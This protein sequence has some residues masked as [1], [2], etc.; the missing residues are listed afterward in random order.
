MPYGRVLRF[1]RKRPRFSRKARFNGKKKRKTYKAGSINRNHITKSIFQ[2]RAGR[3]ISKRW[4]QN[5][6]TGQ[7]SQIFV[8][9]PWSATNTQ[10]NQAYLPK[11][12]LASQSGLVGGDN[13]D[14]GYFGGQQVDANHHS[15]KDQFTFSLMPV[16]ARGFEKEMNT[17]RQ[18]RCVGGV[19][20]LK[21][22][23]NKTTVAN[24]IGDKDFTIGAVGPR[25]Y[26]WDQA[27]WLFQK[28]GVGDT[29]MVPVNENQFV[30]LGCKPIPLVGGKAITIK[31]R[32]KGLNV[33]H[34][35]YPP[36]ITGGYDN[37]RVYHELTPAPWQSTNSPSS[38]DI[39]PN[40]MMSQWGRI[41]IAV[42][43][44]PI[45]PLQLQANA[46]TENFPASAGMTQLTPD[47][48]KVQVTG[49]V[50]MQYK[51]KKHYTRNASTVVFN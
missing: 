32:A 46:I 20:T 16:C 10:M 47:C 14:V 22:L 38:S 40:V 1:K 48:C 24:Q 50:F 43:N 31:M 44:C 23:W 8:T 6:Q 51:G 35:M 25:V 11:G 26:I 27:Q 45:A 30:E 34:D 19:L 36:K 37:S 2:Q 4:S 39:Q 9:H 29:D 21:P 28:G 15:N 13:Y 17:Y 18:F 49:K 33:M 5:K 12:L 41:S 42:F 3:F 7:H